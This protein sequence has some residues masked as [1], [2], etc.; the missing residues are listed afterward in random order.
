MQEPFDFHCHSHHSDGV[1]SPTALVQ[2]A[3][4]HGIKTIALTD[5]DELG[6]LTEA[7]DAAQSLGLDFL[8][9][10]EISSEFDQQS[11]HV[12]GLGIDPDHF[13]LRRRLAEVRGWR[14]HRAEA[15][16]AGLEAAGVH[17]ALDGARHYATN[18]ELI[19]RT[20]FAR[21][22][23]D[24]G[25]CANKGEVFA[26]YMKPGKPGYVPQRWLPLPEAIELIR[27][28]GGV[29]VLAHPARYELSS[30]RHEV[31]LT[32]FKQLGG[33][34]IE[35]LCSA[36]GPEEWA[37]YGA[38]ARRLGLFASVGSDFHAPDESRIDFG[39]LPLLAR[40]LPSIL[41]RLLSHA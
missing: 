19:S 29:A 2:R 16:A 6:G 3:A 14:L 8:A 1:L 40:S 12:V 41:D 31:L 9:G 17:G 36:H 23:V 18:P 25:Y 32:T 21:Y 33:E 30:D 15:I 35:V 4:A 7:A 27:A 39:Q 5:H 28:A 37:R 20:H 22:L 38:L 13:G 24:A 26:R 10:V 11:V 34:G